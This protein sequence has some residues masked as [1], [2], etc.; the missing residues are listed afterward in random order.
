MCEMNVFGEYK[1]SSLTI[2]IKS[3]LTSWNRTLIE[4]TWVLYSLRTVYYFVQTCTSTVLESVDVFPPNKEA[5]ELN[6]SAWISTCVSLKNE[7]KRWCP[8]LD[9]A[10][11]HSLRLSRWNFFPLVSWISEDKCIHAFRY[12]ILKEV[13]K[14]RTNQFST[15]AELLITTML[16]SPDEKDCF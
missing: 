3:L 12:S 7:M 2:N 10:C 6:S 9:E 11:Y 16:N 5:S 8:W 13:C 4:W 1:S 14:R 15:K